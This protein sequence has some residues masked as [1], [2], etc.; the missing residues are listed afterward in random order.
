MKKLILILALLPTMA[1]AQ[2]PIEYDFNSGSNGWSFASN[3][4]LTAGWETYGEITTTLVG[5]TAYPNGKTQRMVSPTVN[6]SSCA[7]DVDV[8]FDIFGKIEDDYDFM[9][10]EY[11]VPGVPGW[12]TVAT[13]TGFMDSTLLYSIPATATK[14]RFILIADGN[15]NSESSINWNDW[16]YYDVDNFKIDCASGL[17]VELISFEGTCNKLYWSTATE[18]NSSHFIVESSVD[19]S[20][21]EYVEYLSAAGNSQS[22]IF[23]TVSI[24]QRK[25]LVYYRLVQYDNDGVY[26]IYDAIAV[27][28]PVKEVIGIYDM[29]GKYIGDDLNISQTGMYIIMY[30]DL[31]VK[32]IMK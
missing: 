3:G 26:K 4:T 12:T 17:P 7:L 1:Y 2:F 5:G 30:D 6:L 24:A 16:Y 25:E 22:T 27:Y 28:C 23:Y 8:S 13:F 15:I 31:S 20:V 14:F 11:K 19:G 10:F 21:W 32:R 29:M 9:Y 18:Y